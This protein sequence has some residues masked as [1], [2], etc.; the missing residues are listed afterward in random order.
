MMPIYSVSAEAQNTKYIECNRRIQ[1]LRA[2]GEDVKAYGR[3]WAPKILRAFPD[4][5]CRRWIIQVKREGRSEGDVML[6]EVL[7]EEVHGA[8][9]AQKIRGE[10]LLASNFTPTAPTLQVR[11]KSGSTS[12]RSRRSVDPFCVFCESNSQWAQDCKAVVKGARCSARSV[13]RDII[14]LFVWT[15][16]Q[17]LAGQVR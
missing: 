17:Q 9:T 4:D 8:L 7:G 10:T 3:V 13:R 16:K 14:S 5:I 15:R 2:M 1:A 6:M 12:R 11:S